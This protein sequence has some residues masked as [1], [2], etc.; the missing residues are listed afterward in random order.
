MAVIMDET[1]DIMA[2]ILSE[3]NLGRTTS[4]A[5]KKATQILR[6]FAF[7]G[8]FSVKHCSKDADKYG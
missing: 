7:V 8:F 6:I 4:I 1:R 2:G 3:L 5:P